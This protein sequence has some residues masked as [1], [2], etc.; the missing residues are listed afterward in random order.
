MTPQRK[1][2]S[3]PLVFTISRRRRHV[4][5]LTLPR[6]FKVSL[7]SA[8]HLQND[9]LQYPCSCRT[10]THDNV[11]Y[12]Q[13]HLEQ[14][15]GRSRTPAVSGRKKDKDGRYIRPASLS[16][17]AY[18]YI[19]CDLTPPLETRVQDMGARR[20]PDNL[21]YYGF[22]ETLNAYYEIIS[23]AKLLADATTRN[24]ILFEKLN[25]PTAH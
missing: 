11:L 15:R 5:W 2:G 1:P 6:F 10:L 9:I 14:G 20:T 17:P 13:Q 18:C 25:L 19:I 12:H 7:R 8:G 16:I 21:G 22:N 4:S 24:R 3:T 23:Y